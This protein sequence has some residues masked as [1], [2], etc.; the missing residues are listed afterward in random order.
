MRRFGQVI[1][2][3]PERFEDYKKLHAA[4]WPEILD[5]IHA[6]GLR[7]YSIYRHEG[8]LFAYFEY[9]GPDAEFDRRMRDLTNAPRMREWWNLTEPMQIPD[10][11]RRKGEWWMNLEELFHAD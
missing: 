1:G 4:A 2:L 10:A 5:A 9:H 7:N 11:A 6:A 8:F 3:R